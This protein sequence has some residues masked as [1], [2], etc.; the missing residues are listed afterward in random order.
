MDACCVRLSVIHPDLARFTSAINQASV[1]LTSGM[2]INRLLCQYEEKTITLEQ[3]FI[4]QQYQKH[5]WPSTEVMRFKQAALT[6]LALYDAIAVS[7]NPDASHNRRVLAKFEEYVLILAKEL[8]SY[9][10]R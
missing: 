2:A 3:L 1:I 7:E 5:L 4:D 6:F 8:V 10:Q 9:T